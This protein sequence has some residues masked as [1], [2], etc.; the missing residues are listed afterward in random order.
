LT[1]VRLRDRLPTPE[2]PHGLLRSTLLEWE[3]FWQSSV[4]DAVDR[5]ADLAAVARLFT[6]R[7][8][9]ERAHRVYR[10]RP[11]V[12]GSA[13]QPALSPAARLMTWLAPAMLALEDRFGLS[14]R[15][16]AQLGLNMIDV[17]RQLDETVALDDEPDPRLMVDE[18]SGGAT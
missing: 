6:L 7:D 4:A 9:F 18:R 2:P 10:R 17:Q 5:E 13:G 3:R 14:P 15:M 16:R 12:P 11:F 1:V 8:E